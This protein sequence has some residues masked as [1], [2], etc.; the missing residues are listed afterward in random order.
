MAHI[1]L[2]R[3]AVELR[4]LGK[5]YGQIKSELGISKST[6]SGWLKAYPLT[7]EQLQLLNQDK[8]KRIEKYRQTM[9][10]KKEMQL[11]KYYDEEK[12]ILLPLTQRE[13]L[14]AGIFLYWGEGTK[15]RN[16]S[17]V[18]AN[19]DPQLVQFALLWMTKA[20]NIPK[21]KIQ[22]LVHL[23]KDMNIEESLDYWSSLLKIPKTQFARPYIK[24]TDRSAIDYKGYGHGTCN[25]RVYKTEL[26]EKI[27][28]A[29][30]AVGD[31]AAAEAK[32]L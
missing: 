6:L 24:A 16:S 3:K 14:I 19:T 12:R 29:I 22:V 17:L 30:K 10:L 23:Y 7:P 13:L 5:S 15:A 25:L 20:L 11:K 32:N 4:L 21:S 27:L 1:L 9:L 31:Y 8:E 2:R 26:K 28:M 18:V